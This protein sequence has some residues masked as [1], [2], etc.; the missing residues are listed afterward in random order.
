MAAIGRSSVSAAPPQV[1]PYERLPGI[2]PVRVTRLDAE[3][4]RDVEPGHSHAHHFLVLAYFDRGGGSL[5]IGEHEWAVHAG[6]AYVVAPGEVVGVGEDVAGLARAR[7]WAVSFPPEGLGPSAPD[8][9]LAW[10]A[11]P[12]LLPFARGAATGAHRFFVP[13]SERRG[14]SSHFCELERELHERRDGY[15]EAA[16]ARLTLLLVALARLASDVAGDLA[17]RDEPLLAEVF[18]I[19]EA[20]YRERLSLADV[21]SALSLT[22]GH[23]TTVVRRK[24]GRTVQDWILERRLAEARRL[25]VET[26]WTVAEVGR[27]AGY[28]DPVYFSRCFRRAHGTTPLRWRRAGRGDPV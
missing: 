24:T 2:P 6:D 7:G 26:D 23:L 13:T 11:H 12:L 28:P 9:L 16:V 1:Y 21:A 15:G 27:S 18:G 10:R 4:L 5:R 17:V 22:P 8:A 20:R 19:I 25:L 14:W 3:A